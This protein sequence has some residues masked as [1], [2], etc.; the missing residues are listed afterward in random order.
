MTVKTRNVLR[1]IRHAR[2]RKT[3]SGTVEIPRMAVFHSLKHIYVQFIDDENGHTLASA[4]TLDPSIRG[5]LPGTCN[6]EAAKIVGKIAAER[7]VAKGIDQVVFDRG[8]HKYHGKV[9][10]LAEAAREA[11]LKF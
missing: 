3:L 4:S 6:V 2:L 10:A 1:E 5:S 7:A 8:G 9:K 11:G